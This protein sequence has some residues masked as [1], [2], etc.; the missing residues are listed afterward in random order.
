MA[1]TRFREYLEERKNHEKI[2][3]NI[4]RSVI[5]RAPRGVWRALIPSITEKNKGGG[6][7][8]VK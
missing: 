5:G 6:D 7:K 2:E 1:D 3:H 4:K 8:R